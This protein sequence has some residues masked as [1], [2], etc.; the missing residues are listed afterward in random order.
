MFVGLKSSAHEHAAIS[1]ASFKVAASSSRSASNNTHPLLTTHQKMNNLLFR[2]FVLHAKLFHS[3]TSPV[4]KYDASETSGDLVYTPVA[5]TSTCNKSN[6]TPAGMMVEKVDNSNASNQDIDTWSPIVDVLIQGR[7]SSKKLRVTA[8]LSAIHENSYISQELVERLHPRIIYSKNGSVSLQRKARV[9]LE[10][11]DGFVLSKFHAM[12][13]RK[14][15]SQG[16]KLIL[17]K[18]FLESNGLDLDY[19]TRTCRWGNLSYDLL[20]GAPM[21]LTC[22]DHQTAQEVHVEDTLNEEGTTNVDPY[23]MHISLFKEQLDDRMLTQYQNIS[24][25]CEPTVANMQA[26]LPHLIRRR[27]DQLITR[28]S[29]EK[30]RIPDRSYDLLDDNL[31]DEKLLHFPSNPRSYRAAWERQLHPFNVKMRSFPDQLKLN[32]IRGGGLRRNGHLSGK[33][34]ILWTGDNHICN[35]HLTY[36]FFTHF[37][38]DTEGM[39]VDDCV[40]S[41]MPLTILSSWLAKSQILDVMKE[42][43]LYPDAGS[44]ATHQDLCAALQAHEI[45]RRPC[46]QSPRT[47]FKASGSKTSKA[48]RHS[49][50]SKHTS[51]SSS[52]DSRR[53]RFPPAPPSSALKREIVRGFCEDLSEENILEEGCAVCGCLGPKKDMVTITDD[54]FD[55]SILI[56]PTG[57]MTRAERGSSRE[58]IHNIP[59]PVLDPTCDKVCPTCLGPLKK[60][61]LPKLALANGNWL[62]EVPD[63]LKG[64]TFL[65]NMLISRVRHNACVLKV[66]SSGQYKMRA[67]AVMFNVPMPKVYRVLPPSKE[68]LEEILA[69][70]FIGPEPTPDMHKR[71]PSFVRRNKVKD[72][73]EWLKVNHEEYSDLEISYSNLN[74]YPEGGPP[75]I[76]D[77]RPAPL[78][79]TELENK[80]VYETE[81]WSAV[82]EGECPLIVH[83]LTLEQLM[84]PQVDT[85]K[86]MNAAKAHFL[87]GGAA[88]A[89]GRSAEPESI[90]SNPQLYPKAFP[91]LFP[92]G[93][94]GI[95][96]KNGHS[97]VGDATRKRALL[98][99]HD[100]RF[101]KDPIFSLVALNHEQIKS[102]TTGSFVLTKKA[103]FESIKERVLNTDVGIMEEVMKKV[104]KGDQFDLTSEAEKACFD[105]IN[106]LDHIGQFVQGSRTQKRYMRNEIWSLIAAKGAPSWFITFAPMDQRHPVSIYNAAEDTTVFPQFFSEADRHRMIGNNPTACAKFFNFMVNAFIKNVLG[107]NSSH[108]G[109]FGKTEGYYGTVEEQG[110]LTLHLHTMIWIKGA[111]TPQQIRDR[112]TAKDG[113][114]QTQ[115]VDYLEGCH[116]GS[117]MTGCAAEVEDNY[118]QTRKNRSEREDPLLRLPEPP[119]DECVLH[120]RPVDTCRACNAVVQWDARFQQTVDEIIHRCNIHDCSKG[121][122]KNPR[123]PNC[124]ARFPREILETTSVDQDSGYLKMRHGEQMLNTY[125]ELLTYLMRSNTDVTSLLSGTALKAVIAYT[126]DYITKPGLRTH[127]MMEVI[128]SVFTRNCEYLQGDSPRAEKARKLMVQMVNAL[129]VKQEVGSPMACA[130]L[131]GHPDHYTNYKFKTFYWRMYVSEIKKSW[132]LLTSDDA[133]EEPSVILSRGKDESVVANSPVIDYELRPLALQNL[134]LYDWIR[135][136]EKQKIPKSKKKKNID[137]HANDSDQ[138]DDP[139]DTQDGRLYQ[140]RGSLSQKTVVNEK[141]YDM[142]DGYETDSTLIAGD[143]NDHDYDDDAESANEFEDNLSRKRSEKAGTFRFRKEHAQYKTHRLKVHGEHDAWIPNFVGGILPRKDKGDIEE[144][145]RTMLT[146][147]KPW[148]NPSHLKHRA[149]SWHAAFTEHQFTDRQKEIMDFFHVRYECNDA[150]DDFRAQRVGEAKSL[151]MNWVGGQ[152]IRELD[153]EAPSAEKMDMSDEDLSGIDHAFEPDQIGRSAANAVLNMAGMKHALESVGWIS[154][155]YNTQTPRNEG[156]KT[157]SD[158]TIYVEPMTDERVFTQSGE[159]TIDPNSR[160]LPV[161]R[162]LLV[163]KRKTVI[164][165]KALTAPV[166]DEDGIQ[167]ERPNQ[168]FWEDQVRIVNKSFMKKGFKGKGPGDGDAGILMDEIVRTFTL[169]EEQERAFRIIANHSL[170]GTALAEPLRMYIGGMAGTGKSQVIKALIRF[171]EARGKSYAFLIL[172][173]TGSAA[174]LVSGSTYHSVLGFRGSNKLDQDGNTKADPLAKGMSAQDSIRSRIRNVEYVFIDEISMVDCLSLYNISAQMNLAMRMDDV[175][176]AGKSMIFAGDFAQLPPLHTAGPALYSALVSSTIHTTNSVSTQKKSI[177]KA[178]WHQFTVVVLLKQNMRQKSQSDED[179]RFR[180]L[181]MNLRMNSCDRDDIELMHSR[182]PRS[183]HPDIDLNDP[184]FAHESMIT[185]LNV[186]RDLLN[187]VGVLKFAETKK[188]ELRTFY[189]VDTFSNVRADKTK[190]TLEHNPIRS[191]NLI[192]KEQ[193]NKILTIQP[194]NTM[195]VPGRLSICKGL[196]VLLK[197]NDATELNVTN[198]AEGFVRDW[199]ESIS[200]EGRPILEVVFVEL[201][202]PPTSVKLDGLPLNVVPICRV[203]T[204]ILVKFPD[205]TVLSIN[206]DQVPLLPNFAITDYASQGRTR[207][208]NI[209]DLENCR[210]H[211]SVYTCLSRASTLKGTVIFRMCPQGKITGGLSGYLKQEFRELELLNEITKLRWEDKLKAGVGGNTRSTLLKSYMKVYGSKSCP[212]HVHSA[213]RWGQR[214]DQALSID[215]DDD[216]DFVWKSFSTGVSANTAEKRKSV[217]TA[218]NGTKRKATDDD[219]QPRADIVRPAKK[220]RQNGRPEALRGLRWNKSTQTCAYDSMLTVLSN[221]YYNN[222]YEW[223]KKMAGLNPL[224]TALAEKWS[225]V[226]R[227]IS[228]DHAEEARNDL[229]RELHT[230]DPHS[231]PMDGTNWTDMSS[232]ISKLMQDESGNRIHYMRSCSTCG[233]QTPLLLESPVWSLPARKTNLMLSAEIKRRFDRTSDQ[234]CVQCRSVTVQEKVKLNEHDPPPFVAFH[235]EDD[236]SKPGG[237]ACEPKLTATCTIGEKKTMYY[238]RGLIYWDKTHFTC[239]LIDKRKEVYY[240]DGITTGVSCIHEGRLS[241]LAEPYNTHGKQLTYVVLSLV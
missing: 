181:L 175:A 107:V 19:V 10:S 102:S 172:A 125:N 7:Q 148:S 11:L 24:R 196:P 124:K 168:S 238:L 215:Y 158:G 166:L 99:Y 221:A 208:I 117:F 187:D 151:G 4:A 53:E 131:L 95:G 173:P 94:G 184:K 183:N 83:T 71:L 228:F 216:N 9:S 2:T 127:T 198:G 69:F 120:K 145:G 167:R 112:L 152:F 16:R 42:H 225:K 156:N 134:C 8:Y 6:D 34:L 21:Q 169:N 97:V 116:R 179:A 73:L 68:E 44:R 52:E 217:V 203:K 235:L 162:D 190:S 147:F 138:D 160:T 70:I 159:E 154:D 103:K 214:G 56:D 31:T 240:N 77:Y 82:S 122:C 229:Q 48:S 93:L 185:C 75:V 26:W 189:A 227:D 231:F 140:T 213:V 113:D 163:Q 178:L 109:L 32:N 22:A 142:D 194:G 155:C 119:P 165:E 63:Q 164:A 92:Y 25:L 104:E 39:D 74:Q 110:R 186:N 28:L 199:K 188:Q 72:A 236:R 108:D 135:L 207:P 88:L 174:S 13:V 80:A 50:E 18:D 78:H 29:A 66:H 38:G 5:I 101:Q 15:C 36:R 96:N 60:G 84:A 20:S 79:E 126:T 230:Q 128:K 65:E 157:A 76:P 237:S 55:K 211:L 85:Q 197:R 219:P 40:V 146:L 209:V 191:G 226:L 176:F 206:R 100:K 57:R 115:L 218:R 3:C 222:P 193:A 204:Q 150:R 224:M 130:Y 81:D 201:K 144:Y 30:V 43:G 89:I 234:P 136:V 180:K 47:Y 141:V 161:W 33:D 45:E 232:L 46:C 54:L 67:N 64:L 239:R 143:E 62:G 153:R 195:H 12:I 106:D 170:L 35:E 149:Q 137:N 223:G 171:F 200:H 105:L 59:G 86:L 87:Q 205:D 233:L 98:M 90:Y 123:F 210:N 202:N 177:G 212:A 139:Q 133:H 27:M 241:T 58:P 220:A 51:T 23:T 1:Q 37:A 49:T 118:K 129:T 41:D 192:P 14:R 61:N 121:W 111:L 132:G 17:G 91:W 182:V 114:F